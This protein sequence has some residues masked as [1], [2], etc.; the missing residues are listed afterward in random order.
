MSDVI[1]V[2]RVPFVCFFFDGVL[3]RNQRNDLF[4]L[5]LLRVCFY[6]SNTV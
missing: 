6:L 3:R 2:D 1:S 4:S 5:F